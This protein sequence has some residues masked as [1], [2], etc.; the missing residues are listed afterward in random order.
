MSL[1]HLPASLNQLTPGRWSVDPAHT[2][3]GFVARHMMVTKVRGSFTDY[4]ADIIVADDPLQ[5]TINVEVQMASVNTGDDTRDGHLRTNDFFDIENHPTMTLRSTGF[6]RKG[7]DFV[8][9]TELTIKGIT[10]PVDF[11]LEFGGVAQDPWGG[12]RA[13][14]EASAVVNRKDWGIEWNAPLEAGGLL[15]GDKVTLELDVELVKD[16]PA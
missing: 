8:M 9:H 1:E 2:K 7:D 13:G 6:E 4:S 14:F 5:S 16:A 12:T 15:V 10:K 3:V 11:D